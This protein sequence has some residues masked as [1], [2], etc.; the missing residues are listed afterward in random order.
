MKILSKSS[1]NLVWASFLALHASMVVAEGD[2]NSSMTPAQLDA[3]QQLEPLKIENAIRMC[4]HNV[5][6]GPPELKQRMLDDLGER[7]C[8]Q[9]VADSLS[10]SNNESNVD[11]GQ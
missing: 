6:Y 11:S 7:T 2:E 8:A 4:Q 5:L 3:M 10:Q 9:W 1:L